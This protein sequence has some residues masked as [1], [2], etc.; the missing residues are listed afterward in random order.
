MLRE[1]GNS[2]HRAELVELSEAPRCAHGV[3]WRFMLALL[4]GE[5]DEHLRKYAHLMQM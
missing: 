3:R 5:H 4:K 2:A 1:E